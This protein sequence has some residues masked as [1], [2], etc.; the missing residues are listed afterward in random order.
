MAPTSPRDR[1]LG[2]EPDDEPPAHQP[3]D[4]SAKLVYREKRIVAEFLAK[5][6]FGKIIPAGVA[7]RIDFEGLQPAPT[8]HVDPKLRTSRHADPVWR[9]PFRDSWLYVVLL[10]EFQAGSDWRMAVRILL[11]TALA[12][13]YLAKSQEASRTRGLP[14]VLPIVVH[15]GPERWTA[16]ARLEDLLADEAKAFLPFVLGHQFVL[17]SEAEEAREIERGTTAREAALKLR[18]AANST[19]FEE[20]LPV[21]R[22][23]LPRDSAAREGLVAWV[24]SLMIDQGAKEEDVAKVKQMGDLTGGVAQI[25][26][27]ED[28]EKNR[29][30]V[31]E[32][33]RR[34]V[35]GEVREEVRQEV[36][37]EVREEVRREVREEVRQEVREEV[38]GE[39]RREVREEL[40]REVREE[41]R[42]EGR[43]EVEAR[44]LL[45]RRA[46]LVRLARRKFDAETAKELGALLEEVSASERLAEVADLVI[47]C[48]SGQELLAHARTAS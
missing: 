46:T 39:I 10:F 26:L 29:R 23:L 6:V 12:Y 38:R 40:R 42:Q 5:H 15:V 14:P 45:E 33:V 8:E 20:A 2:R 18:Y 13:D 47:D 41:G 28:R 31:R 19:E 43:Q 37:G 21:L 11:E 22:A 4:K 25:W 34:E 48:A 35:R 30:E 7:D 27:A 24:R 44:A 36:R 32:E 1:R 16:P 3:L 9:A 17:V